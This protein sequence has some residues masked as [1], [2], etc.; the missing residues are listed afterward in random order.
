MDGTILQWVLATFVQTQGP[1]QGLFVDPASM[2]SLAN[3]TAM[4]QAL[5]VL[6]RLRRAG[7]L[8]GGAGGRV[9]GG[10]PRVHQMVLVGGLIGNP[11]T[12]A[13]ETTFGAGNTVGWG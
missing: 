7:P 5:E 1:S 3:T 4:A 6:R 10:P 2:A 12:D 13:V 9:L 11:A 8:S